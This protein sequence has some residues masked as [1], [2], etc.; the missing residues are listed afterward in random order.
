V[1]Q[2]VVSLSAEQGQVLGLL[3]PCLSGMAVDRA[4][5]S[6]DLVRIWVHAVADGAACPDCGTWSA[7][8]HDRYPRR[9]CEAAA[10]GR[11][12]MIWLA[13]RV[14]CCG[15]AGCATKTFAE[16]PAGLASRYAR[17]TPLLAG[18]LGA[19]AAA[20][21]GR[22]GSRLARAVLAV[23]VSR[24]ALVRMLLAPPDPPAGRVRVLGAG[25]FALRKG[26]AY[27][28]LLVDMETGRPVDVLPD[29]E[30]ATA[31]NG[32]ARTPGPR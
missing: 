29:R 17:R 7:E 5:V 22:A 10:G 31:G 24:H 28:T 12:V 25:D 14:L 19:V 23:Q 21:A 8:V 9:L 4:E 3:L 26:L 11:R 18:Q 30:Q 20:L 32:C 6:G 16:Q 15:S 2:A 1:S 27:A 13:A